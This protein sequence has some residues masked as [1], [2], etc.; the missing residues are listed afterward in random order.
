[1]T[2]QSR[3]DT[4][5][6]R[7]DVPE[8]ATRPGSGD[9]IAWR[10]GD[11][12]QIAL[13]SFAHAVQHFYT[14]ALAFSYPFVVKEFGIS[15]ATL[16]VVLGITGVVGGL[17]Q[18]VAGLVRRVSA[19]WLLVGQDVGLAA[20][21]VLA[22]LAPVFAVFA[23][24]R[25]LAALVQWPQ[26]PVGSAYLSERVPHRRSLALS[27]HT[28]GGSIG[29]LMVPLIAGAVTA[30]WGWRWGLAVFVPGLIVGAAFLWRGMD[31]P[32]R[33]TTAVSVG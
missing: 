29:T 13:L 5:S 10:P 33:R 24:A 25:C 2:S 9:A 14:A 4:R 8:A 22:A 26:H 12:A 20:T 19:R 18:G 11:R 3:T 1:M 32:T 30:G 27:W 16:G 21:M 23:L 31:D 28:I 6:G 17:L 15:Y 7:V